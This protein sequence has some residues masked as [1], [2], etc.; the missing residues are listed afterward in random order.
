[1]G[2]SFKRIIISCLIIAL[3][4][5]IDYLTTSQIKIIAFYLIPVFISTYYVGVGL[6]LAFALIAVI[7]N[8][9]I[10][11]WEG[12][13]TDSIIIINNAVLFA[14]YGVVVGL[15]NR[16]R[17]QNLVITASL[18]EKEIILREIHHR[19]KNQIASLLSIVSLSESGNA[20]QIIEALSGRLNAYMM[21]YA[22]LCYDS[23]SQTRIHVCRYF[24]QIA[25]YILH[26]RR[27]EAADIACS[28]TGGDFYLDN[29]VMI[30]LGLIVNELL[31]NSLKHAFGAGSGSVYLDVRT[32][33]SSRL[34]LRYRDSGPGFDARQARP[35]RG[36]GMMMIESLVAR[37]HGTLEY[38]RSRGSEFILVFRD[39]ELYDAP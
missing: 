15:V 23:A 18:R 28:I 39:V 36:I 8:F 24:N 19:M 29:H 26:S 6:G 5:L 17:R 4:G 14:L 1:M 31:T 12:F 25:E 33:N 10:E 22:N 35:G 38:S 20:D 3:I 2:K 27:D 7:F 16:M 32:E 9:S 34:V 21:L 37:L 30:T 11:Y 13:S